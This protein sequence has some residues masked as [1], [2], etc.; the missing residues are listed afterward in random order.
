MTTLA[1][2]CFCVFSVSQLMACWLN[3]RKWR[4]INKPFMLLSL[5]LYYIVGASSPEPFVI[6]ALAF[7]L[8]GDIMLVFKR[9]FK[10]GGFS[11][12]LAHIC[13]IIAF[14]KRIDFNAVN[15][16]ALAAL[17]AFY[18][19]VVFFMAGRIHRHVKR[20]LL[21]PSLLYLSVECL[22]SCFAFSQLLTLGG[23]AATLIFVGSV[24]FIVSDCVLYIREY[25]KDIAVPKP[26]FIVMV[27]YLAAQF[28]I[29]YGM[30]NI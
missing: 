26:S 2:I 15:V 24:C 27:T 19:A 20:S 21:I 3:N 25:R 10:V 6:A 22:M 8:L 17:A 4:S 1:L 13:Y 11:F 28:L 9:F 12:G 14:C 30:I 16:I 23:M 7:C 29:V 5:M 18:A